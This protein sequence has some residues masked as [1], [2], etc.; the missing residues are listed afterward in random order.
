MIEIISLLGVSGSGKSTLANGLSARLT[1]IGHEV[2]VVKKD[3][4][5]KVLAEKMGSTAF[6]A[7]TVVGPKKIT[8]S[9]LHAYMNAQI[10]QALEER[11]V[12]ILEGGTRTR[13]AQAETLD[14]VDLDRHPFGIVM[15]K[16]PFRE[17][18]ERLKQRRAE[19]DRSDD[20]YPVIIGKLAGQYLRPIL[21]TDAPSQ[22][23]ADVW[24]VDATLPRSELVEDVLDHILELQSPEA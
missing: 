18:I 3:E 7:E 8:Q 1:E 10:K 12:V 23:D 5:I 9:D 20:T 21:S 15:L 6:S 24:A 4:A 19:E 13:K 11:K 17:V 2:D 22:R 16:L 14:G